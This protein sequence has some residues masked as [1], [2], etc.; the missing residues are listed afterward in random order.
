[1]VTRL[2]LVAV[3]LALT[4]LGVPAIA[5]EPPSKSADM[6]DA[7]RRAAAAFAFSRAKAKAQHKPTT[8]VAQPQDAVPAVAPMPKPASPTLPTAT[9]PRAPPRVVLCRCSDE[10]CRCDPDSCPG[11]CP[12]AV[13]K[14]TAMTDLEKVRDACVRVN[15]GPYS[16]SGTVIWSSGGKS[17]VLTAAHVVKSG[18]GLTVRGGGKTHPAFILGRDDAADLVALLVSGTLPAVKVS[19]RDPG[20]GSEVLMVGCT[21]LWSRGNILSQGTLS[22]RTAWQSSYE[23]DQG[24]SGAGV[25]AGGELVGVHFGKVDERPSCTA[26]QSVRT[27][28]A[29]VLDRNGPKKAAVAAAPP[30]RV[31]PAPTTYYSLP[32]Y[33]GGCPGGVCPAPTYRVYPS[34]YPSVMPAAPIYPYSAPP[35]YSGGCP[36]GVC[37]APSTRPRLFR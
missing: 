32:S 1:M 31:T 24:D 29:S 25:F 35:A 33:S 10:P 18:G 7:Q 3:C 4:S 9:P 16:G 5:A 15:C 37:P 26:I 2:K 27:F 22:G 12:V 17:V 36:G 21:S 28:V 34:G 30:S 11:A 23:S 8:A 13:N 19:Q 14:S 20:V 6:V